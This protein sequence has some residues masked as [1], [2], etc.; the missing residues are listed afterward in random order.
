[1]GF[2]SSRF[3]KQKTVLITGHTGFKGSWLSLYLSEMGAVVHGLAL[4]PSGP[5]NLFSDLNLPERIVRDFRVDIRDEAA[6][7]EAIAQSQ[8]DV[9]FHLA[10]QA[11]VGEGL[12][13]PLNTIRTNVM[14]T[15]NLLDACRKI[16]RR[17]VV[18][19]V[20]TDKVYSNENLGQVFREQD[21]LGGKDPYSAS[22]AAAD[23]IS[24][25]F[26]EAYFSNRDISVGVA[27][28]GNVIGGG[29]WSVDRIFPDIARA[30]SSGEIAKIRSPRATRPWQHVLEPLRGYLLLAEK[31]DTNHQTCGPVNFGPDPRDCLTVEE[32]VSISSVY[33]QGNPGWETL[34]RGSPHE[35]ESLAIDNSLASKLLGIEPVWSSEEAIE[36]TTKWYYRHS[37]GAEAEA[38]CL[39]DI[40]AYGNKNE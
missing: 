5:K 4:N 38:L 16:G 2:P 12:R 15:A 19:S 10:A 3:W 20:T 33:W 28:A 13:S 24:Q 11:L 30:W 37:L 35:V 17:C 34:S 8:P 32:L 39:G 7:H 23:I 40:R 29:D 14:G 27:R 18:I 21:P 25:A 1:M 9:I 26:E 22:K 36:R 6:V 31:L